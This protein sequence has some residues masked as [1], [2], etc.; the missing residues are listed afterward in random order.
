MMTLETARS[1]WSRANAFANGAQAA[2]NAPD[3][4][5]EDLSGEALEDAFFEALEAS[6]IAEKALCH[7]E[8]M[9]NL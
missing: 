3:G 2:L 6:R 1:T 5:F 9:A 4:E 7:Y 8:W